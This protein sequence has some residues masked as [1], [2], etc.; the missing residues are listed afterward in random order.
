MLRAIFYVHLLVIVVNCKC[1]QNSVLIALFS[2]IA[3]F[4]S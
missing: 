1:R 3:P 2:K 4:W